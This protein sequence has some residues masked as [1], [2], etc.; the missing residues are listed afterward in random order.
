[1]YALH[2]YVQKGWEAEKFLGL[3]LEDRLFYIASMNVALK[4]REDFFSL[5]K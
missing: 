5:K 3:S 1:M 2:Y 4:E